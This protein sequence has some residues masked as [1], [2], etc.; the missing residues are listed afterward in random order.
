MMKVWLMHDV[1]NS[2][3]MNYPSNNLSYNAKLFLYVGIGKIPCCSKV[4]ALSIKCPLF[5][6]YGKLIRLFSSIESSGPS[7]LI[8]MSQYKE[9][10]T[11]ED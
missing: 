9:M 5:C 10:L 3:L 1:V 7:Y 11:D 8:V 4:M 2:T 6:S